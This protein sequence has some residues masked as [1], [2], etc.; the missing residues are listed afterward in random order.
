MRSQAVGWLFL[1][2]TLVVL[3]VFGVIP[4]IYV[5]VVGFADWNTFAAD[6]TARFAGAGNYRRLVFDS[7]FLYSLWLTLQFAFWAVLSEIVLGY[8][9]AQLLMKDFPLKGFFRTVH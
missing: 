3:S 8:F 2:P 7:Q 4:F 6:P 1:A 5:L 9:L